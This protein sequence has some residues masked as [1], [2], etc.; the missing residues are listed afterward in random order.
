MAKQRQKS[1]TYHRAECLDTNSHGFNLENC[2][3]QAIIHLPTVAD[4]SIERDGGSIGRL[5]HCGR[6][7]NRLGCLLH[8]TFEAPG[9]HASIVPS[10]V[11]GVSELQTQTHPPPNSAEFMDGDAFLYVVGNHVCLCTTAVRV[12]TVRH[13]LQ[14]LFEKANIEQNCNQFILMNAANTNKLSRI[15]NE[16]IREIQLKASLTHA[17]AEYIR[18]KNH[19]I[20]AIGVVA[21]FFKEIFGHDDGIVDDALRVGLIFHVDGRSKSRIR[22][23]RAKLQKIAENIVQNEEKDDDYTIILESGEKI[24]FSDIV[25]KKSVEIDGE[26]KTVRREAAFEALL[27]YYNELKNAGKLEE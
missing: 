24:R 12:G 9:E 17:S 10:P 25:L 11:M 15:H 5:A 27:L 19:T 21:E 3:N 23:G 8:L 6:P 7:K 2:I 4:R 14:K 13:F 20:G 26:G 1:L 16:G 18:R 22:L